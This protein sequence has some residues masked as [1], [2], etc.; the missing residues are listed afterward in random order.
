M[1]QRDTTVDTNCIEQFNGS[2]FC[3]A[4]KH[5]QIGSIGQN[6][7]HAPVVDHPLDWVVHLGDFSA[8]R[9]ALDHLIDDS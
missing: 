7:K 8:I 5:G 3:A 9:L 1:L 2:A 6:A 4:R